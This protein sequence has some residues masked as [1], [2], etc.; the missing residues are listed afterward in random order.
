MGSGLAFG[1]DRVVG[2]IISQGEAFIEKDSS[3][4]GLAIYWLILFFH[5]IEAPP[6]WRSGRRLAGSC[7]GSGGSESLP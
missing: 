4:V 2:S 6:R 3:R 5:I 7:V 1:I